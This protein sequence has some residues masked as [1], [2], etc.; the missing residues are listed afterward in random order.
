MSLVLLEFVL[1]V[2]TSIG[3]LFELLQPCKDE[4]ENHT[5]GV[6]HDFVVRVRHV[7]DD[8]VGSNKDYNACN[9]GSDE[10]IKTVPGGSHRS[11]LDLFGQKETF[12]VGKG[13]LFIQRPQ[14]MR[15]RHQLLFF[16]FR[17]LCTLKVEV[18]AHVTL[19]LRPRRYHAPA[20]RCV[21]GIL[22]NFEHGISREAQEAANAVGPKTRF[23]YQ[24]VFLVVFGTESWCISGISGH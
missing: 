15:P 1:I 6:R 24:L 10:H 8:R 12:L 17:W 2:A 7:F 3:L 14:S 18:C 23:K 22:P 19:F 11:D 21:T 16:F 13:P 20:I 9:E 5:E 4:L